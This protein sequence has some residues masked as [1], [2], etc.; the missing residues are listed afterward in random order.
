MNQLIS[1]MKKILLLGIAGFLSLAIPVKA[2]LQ[3]G[4]KYAGGTI[5]LNGATYESNQKDDKS[6]SQHSYDHT[7]APEIQAGYF[8]NNTT[9]VG[10]GLRYNFQ[11]TKYKS[12]QSESRGTTHGLQLLPFIRKY[13]TFGAHWSVFLH[14]EIGPG[15]QWAHHKIT[16]SFPEDS[17]GHFWQYGVSVKPGL[18]YQFPKKGWAIE[19]YANVLSLNANYIPFQNNGARNFTFNTGLSTGF[20]SY[21]TLRIAK[22]L[23]K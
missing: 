21:F 9:M 12:V 6:I 22:Y 3:K 17:K 15:Y 20:P 18:V 11:W 4:T 1:V 8:L 7:I 2:Q 13:K 10:L 19:G 5:S 23:S 14:A 16:G